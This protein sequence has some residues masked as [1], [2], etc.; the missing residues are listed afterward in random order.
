[1]QS[2]VDIL[3]HKTLHNILSFP[4]YIWNLTSLILLSKISMYLVTMQKWN[5]MYYLFVLIFFKCIEALLICFQNGNCTFTSFTY[6][7]IN[8]LYSE[9][10][11]VLSK[12]NNW[13][14]YIINCTCKQLYSSFYSKLQRN[15]L[16]YRLN[17]SPTEVKIIYSFCLG[18]W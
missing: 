18:L 1:M 16:M 10:A 12:K 14:I 11:V 2:C 6:L 4:L 17:G 5:I 15:V 3:L 13:N 7:S 8:I 9:K